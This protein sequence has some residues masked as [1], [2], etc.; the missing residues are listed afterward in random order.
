MTPSDTVAA[1]LARANTALDTVDTATTAAGT[2]VTAVG[3]RIT[4]LM[5]QIAAA[6]DVAT[7]KALADR[8]TQEA[9]SLT[10][11]ATALSAMAQDPSNPVPTAVPTPAPA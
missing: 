8:A 4:A 7:A 10:G 9:G 5:A 6:P 1:E 3:A 11:I 2:A